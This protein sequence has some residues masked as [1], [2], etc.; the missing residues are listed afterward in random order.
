MRDQGVGITVE[1]FA[2]GQLLKLV[3]SIDATN[4]DEL[5]ST[6]NREG[7]A[8]FQHAIQEAVNILPQF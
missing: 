2:S 8:R 5:L 1:E 3:L 6:A 7:Y 4:F